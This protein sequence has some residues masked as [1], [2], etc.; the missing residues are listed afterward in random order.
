MSTRALIM[1]EEANGETSVIYTH[2]DGYPEHHGPILLRDY[3]DEKSA[4]DLIALGDLSK[5]DSSTKCPPGHS[6]DTP[7]KGYCIAYG[8]DRKEKGVEA[9]KFSSLERAEKDVPESYWDVDYLYL[10][11]VKTGIWSVSVPGKSWS[12]L[13]IFVEQLRKSGTI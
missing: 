6:Y 12:S 9:R 13:A 10:F 2:W 5:L 7:K 4:R 11:F 1:L 3:A 8:R